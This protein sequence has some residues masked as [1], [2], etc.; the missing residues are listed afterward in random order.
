MSEDLSALVRRVDEDRWL[1][2]RFAAEPVRARLM[3]LYALNYEIAHAAEAA[4]EPGLGAIRL[5]WWRDELETISRGYHPSSHPALAAIMQTSP[6]SAFAWS[7]QGLV[8]AH[9]ADLERAPFAAFSDMQRYV[10]ATAGL[11]MRAAVDACG[12]SLTGAAQHA[13]V[14]DAARAWGFTGLMRASG[15]WQMRGRTLLPNGARLED[16]KARVLAAYEAAKLAARLMKA[17]AFPAF[18]YVALV[19]GY[20]RAMAQGRIDTPLLGR[21]ALL[22]GASATGRV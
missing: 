18:G 12:V 2:S 22:I 17:E 20:L 14:R 16:L 1:A 7:L 9:L 6:G 15:H 19:P 10:D 3:A 5:Q 21:K 8:D 13:F 11:V 4:R